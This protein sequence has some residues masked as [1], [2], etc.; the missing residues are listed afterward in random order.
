MMAL[1]KHGDRT[2]GQEERLPRA[3]EGWPIIYLGVGRG[4][5]IVYSVR[6]FGSMVFRTLRGLAFIGKRSLITV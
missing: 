5:R 2:Y 4:L 6:N 3:Y 1:L